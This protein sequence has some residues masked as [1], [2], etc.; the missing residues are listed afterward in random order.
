MDEYPVWVYTANAP[1]S[2]AITDAPADANLTLFAMNSFA[3]I[4]VALPLTYQGSF[5]LETTAPF[6]PEVIWP[7]ASMKDPT[8]RGRSLV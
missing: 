2:L 4:D 8:G 7:D 3:P 1:I 5:S 6:V